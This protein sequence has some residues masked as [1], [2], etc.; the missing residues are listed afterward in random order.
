MALASKLPT[1]LGSDTPSPADAYTRQLKALLPPGRLWLLD[2]GS[3]ISKVLEALAQELAHVAARAVDLLAESDPRTA[4]ETLSDWERVLGLPDSCIVAIP[5]TTAE[6]QVAV[7]Q[8]FV[9]RGGQTRA[10]FISLASACGYTATITEWEDHPVMRSGFRCGA[11]CY[12]TDWAFVWTMHV[13]PPSGTAL[14]HA[15]LEC[16]ITRAAPA[17]T[18]V[19]FTYL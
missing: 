15:E 8:K 2:A 1:V 5:S 6:R 19:L 11:R 17:H 13:Q 3:W 10:Y 16:I 4:T 18:V 14:S 7:T 12:N 9:R